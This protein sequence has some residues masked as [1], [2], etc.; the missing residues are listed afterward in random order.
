MDGYAVKEVD[1]KYRNKIY[2]LSSDY[3]IYDWVSDNGYDNFSDWV[4]V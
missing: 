3:N 2:R 4:G 1:E